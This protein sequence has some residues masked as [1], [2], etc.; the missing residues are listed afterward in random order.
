MILVSR[1]KETVGHLS[2]LKIKFLMFLFKN[3]QNNNIQCS[4]ISLLNLTVLQDTSSYC[5]VSDNEDLN[6]ASALSNHHQNIQLTSDQTLIG[7][8]RVS[9]NVEKANV[10]VVPRHFKR[11]CYALC[12]DT[13]T[14]TMC[15]P[16]QSSQCPNSRYVL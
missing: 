11:I 4:F 10:V 16:L 14:K 2:F 3:L 15:F 7:E 8:L 12:K 13:G 1:R 6:S 5:N 9:N